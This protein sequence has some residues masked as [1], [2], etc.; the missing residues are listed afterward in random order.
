MIM[1]SFHEVLHVRVRDIISNLYKYLFVLC[2][3]HL[4]ASEGW[5]DDADDRNQAR[6]E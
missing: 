1:N 5:G 4:D 2:S 6:V 3:V